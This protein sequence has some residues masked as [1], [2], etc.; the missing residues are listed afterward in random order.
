LSI[1]YRLARPEDL[2]VAHQ[3]L[4]QLALDD[5]GVTVKGSAAVLRDLTS[6][7]NAWLRVMMAFRGE[8]AFGVATFLPEFSSYRGCVGTFIPDLYVAPEAR[9]LG[10]GRGLIAAAF[11]ASE[12]WGSR[13]VS[14]HVH[15]FNDAARAFYARTGFVVRETGNYLIL[16]GKALDDLRV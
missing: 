11:A 7:P 16:E 6:Q 5:G 13:Y 10:A 2:D 15:D 4:G 9:G 12:D 1:T 3:M 8:T 14:L